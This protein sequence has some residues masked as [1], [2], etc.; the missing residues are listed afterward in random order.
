MKCFGFEFE[1]GIV[2]MYMRLGN[3]GDE[4]LGVMRQMPVPGD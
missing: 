3:A 1:G 4:S 2:I